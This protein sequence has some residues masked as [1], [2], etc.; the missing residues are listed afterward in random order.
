MIVIL[1]ASLGVVDAP[2]TQ[3]L[4]RGERS[5]VRV[6][7]TACPASGMP[8]AQVRRGYPPLRHTTVASVPPPRSTAPPSLLP[9]PQGIVRGVGDYFEKDDRNK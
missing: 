3:T 2:P 8:R 1:S 7:L 5:L 9:T 6:P 4:L